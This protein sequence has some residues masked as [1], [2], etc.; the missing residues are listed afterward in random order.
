MADDDFETRFADWF[1]ATAADAG[2]DF[3]Q[4]GTAATFARYADVDHGQIS[5]ILRGEAI[6]KA[7]TMVKLA[8]V[9]GVTVEEMA[10]RAA[11][12]ESERTERA[13]SREEA[14][15]AL[16]LRDPKDR[17]LVLGLVDRLNELRAE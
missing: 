3:T 2:Y 13:V 1:R 14:L 8:A 7:S 6:P 10:R 9:L 15:L 16:G 17:A 11:G 4:R 12:E 5:R